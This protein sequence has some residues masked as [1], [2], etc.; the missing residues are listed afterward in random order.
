MSRPTD[1]LIDSLAKGAHAEWLPIVLELREQCPEIMCSIRQNYDDGSVVRMIVDQQR[2]A[3]LR[4]VAKPPSATDHAK[5]EHY[6]GQCFQRF[7]AAPP[8]LPDR[9]LTECAMLSK[10]MGHHPNVVRL[11][12]MCI[13][14]H[15][16]VRRA[17]A[18][19]F[20][21]LFERLARHGIVTIAPTLED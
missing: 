20:G 10:E 19:A 2:A 5:T 3:L 21:A 15:P 11:I 1:D 18:L 9:R 12:A 8:G 17:T 16:V 4:E 7:R 6:L 14:V 13:D